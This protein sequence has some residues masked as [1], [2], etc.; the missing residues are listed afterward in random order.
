MQCK[1][2]KKR[3]SNVLVRT[4]PKNINQIS[5]LTTLREKKRRTEKKQKQRIQA[6]S[7]RRRHPNPSRSPTPRYIQPQ[8]TPI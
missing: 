2:G 8:T 3:K 1:A 6:R 4:T 5:K 7:R